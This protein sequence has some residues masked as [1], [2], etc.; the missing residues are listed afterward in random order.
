MSTRWANCQRNLLF[1]VVGAVVSSGV[2]VPVWLSQVRD[3][4]Q[5][6]EAAEQEAATLRAFAV[7]R[8]RIAQEEAERA[9]AERKEWE[10]RWNDPISLSVQQLAISPP[11]PKRAWTDR[12]YKDWVWS[13]L[14]KDIEEQ[15]KR[16]PKM[17][18]PAPPSEP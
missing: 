5:R 18:E 15:K 13:V 3:E 4:R 14:A 8:A 7:E 1:A 16:I 17:P 2:S 6:A 10:R 9:A 11:D 12:D